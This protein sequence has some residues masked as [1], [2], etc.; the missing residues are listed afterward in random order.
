MTVLS[1]R[2]NL[3]EPSNAAVAS[4][5]R[6]MR[7]TKTIRGAMPNDIGTDMK[8]VPS[9][10][11][12]TLSTLISGGMSLASH[13]SD[14][15][16]WEIDKEEIVLGP[17]IG[18]GSFGEVYRAQWRETEVAVKVFLDQEFGVRMLESFRKEVSI[19][20]KLRHPNIV[21]FMGACTKPPFLC[22]VTQYV[23]RGSLFRLL[24]RPGPNGPV[25][26]HRR[27]LQMALDV[28]RGMNYLHTCRPPVIHRDLK[29]PNLLV[30]KDLTI[31]VCDF[32]LSRVR[33]TT[34]LSTKSQAGTPE[35]TAPEV[36][37]GKSCNESSDVYSFGVILWELL[38]GEEP[39]SDKSAMQVVGA[40]GFAG[41]RLA[42]PEGTSPALA[43]LMERCFGE[44]D[45][46]PSFS[47]IIS[48]LKRQVSALVAANFAYSGQL[49]SPRPLQQRT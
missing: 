21:Q 46:R 30:D 42:V 6:A 5:E 23:S 41:Q 1:G 43:D 40:V 49:S 22:I 24:H 25:L 48:L 36:L 28:C 16:G 32:G 2:T 37:Q 38:S 35:W 29:S 47:E 17:R 8:P 18:I 7:S 39:W 20:K 13:D 44:P 3:A 9:L 45:D 31:K 26:D 14:E 34:V 33:H 10:S 11:P 19:M 12:S 4:P 27:R 15:D